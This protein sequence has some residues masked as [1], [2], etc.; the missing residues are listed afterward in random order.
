MRL[1]E[2]FAYIRIMGER[3]LEKFDRIQR[4]RS[5]VLDQWSDVISNI[6]AS[7]IFIYIDNY[8]EGFAPGTA[9]KLQNALRLP[10]AH[11]ADFQQQGSLF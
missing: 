2:D 1:N 5:D 11:A 4:D 10:V 8:F 3:D 7:E 9:A 6:R